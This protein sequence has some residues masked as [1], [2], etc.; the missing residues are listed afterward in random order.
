MENQNS[1]EDPN[2]TPSTQELA[3]PPDEMPAVAVSSEDLP[4]HR[5]GWNWYKDHK[6]VSIPATIL[7]LVVI[8]AAIPW[9]RYHLAG[10][11]VKHDIK[12]SAADSTTNTPISGASIS[13]D[14]KTVLT[15]AN[16]E[17]VL[18]KL[19]AGPHNL[20]VSKKYYKDQTLKLSSPIVGAVKGAQT[21]LEATGR[22]VSFSVAD[23]VDGKA[24]SGATIEAAGTNA[25]TDV[26]GAATLVV[27]SNPAEQKFT[28]T[29]SGYNQS[30][31]TVK[32]NAQ[33]TK[34]NEIKLVPAG[35]IYFFSKRTGKLDVMKASLDGSQPQTVLAGT[36]TEQLNSSLLS[37]SPDWRYVALVLKR[38]A[39]DPTPQ[40]YILSTADDRLLTVETGN[41][42]VGIIGWSGNNLIYSV[43]RLDLPDYQLGKNKLKSYDATSG[44]TI[45]LDQTKATTDSSGTAWEAYQASFLV[46]DNLVFAKSWTING[47]PANQQN[48]LNIIGVDGQ[49]FK[50]VDTFPPGDTIAYSRHSPNAI[51]IWQRP[52]GGEGDSFF[53][54]VVGST[55]KQV[56]ISTDQFYGQNTNYYTS[57]SGKNLLWSEPRD[58]KNTI[59]VGGSSGDNPAS[60]GSFSDLQPYGWY[61]DR[62]VI[63]TK[64]YSEV[65]IMGVRVGSPVKVT[66]YQNTTYYF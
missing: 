66:D 15:N 7:A 63:L 34:P 53:D 45:Q 58:G 43:S 46:G 29:G 24:V 36:G 30:E 1:S 6:K 44:K 47:A 54:Y 27:P 38:S 37:A 64:N 50:Q 16:G 12:I 32:V 8:L 60:I 61:K 26:S 13:Y 20:V 9:S 31:I 5:R 22:Q 48:S 65:Y 52:S 42:N 10:T 25:K 23:Y 19:K 59:L 62:Y 18:A 2:L 35:K 56:T 39:G 41:V 57:S 28:I 55:A 49:G 17:A 21:T 4:F 33:T 40:L 14:G 11:V 3:R 51:Y